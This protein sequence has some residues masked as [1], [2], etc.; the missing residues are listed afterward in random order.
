MI[1]V[2]RLIRIRDALTDRDDRDTMA[3]AINAVGELKRIRQ[4]ARHGQNVPRSRFGDVAEAALKV[5]EGSG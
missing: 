3:D 1:D 5:E 2:D 4:M